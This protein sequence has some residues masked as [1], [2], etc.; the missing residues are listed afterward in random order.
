[1]KNTK[2]YDNQCKINFVGGMNRCECDCG[3]VEEEDKIDEMLK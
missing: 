1:M 3:A 2:D